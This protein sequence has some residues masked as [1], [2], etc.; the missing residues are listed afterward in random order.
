MYSRDQGI[1]SDRVERLGRYRTLQVAAHPRNHSS[2]AS[3][4]ALRGVD[5]TRNGRRPRCG[6]LRTITTPKRN[7]PRRRNFASVTAKGRAA[8]KRA[9][10]AQ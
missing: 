7:R 4:R 2:S 9:T 3:L 8:L 6:F 10:D 1:V 5:M